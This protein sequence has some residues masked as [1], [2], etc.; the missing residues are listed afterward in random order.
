MAAET[1]N[2]VSA[3]RLADR[4]LRSPDDESVWYVGTS[5]KG[6][7]LPPA[8]VCSKATAYFVMAQRRYCRELVY[9]LHFPAINGRMREIAIKP[10]EMAHRATV[11]RLLNEGLRIT[12]A[13]NAGAL[14]AEFVMT[15]AVECDAPHLE[16]A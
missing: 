2:P 6:K 12:T 11:E 5:N 1:A 16:T 10:A 13:A 9:L 4:F 14:L 3:L 15:T 7:P 8:W